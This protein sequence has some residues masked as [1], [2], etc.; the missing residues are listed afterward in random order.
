M[1][2]ASMSRA[3]VC[4]TITQCLNDIS[5]YKSSCC[6]VNLK[7]LL[8]SSS[9]SSPT[10]VASD[11]LHPGC[12]VDFHDGIWNEY[13]MYAVEYTLHI[14]TDQS[15]VMSTVWHWW[16]QHTNEAWWPVWHANKYVLARVLTFQLTD[17]HIS[18]LHI[19]IVLH[20]FCCNAN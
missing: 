5:D 15:A 1:S 11:H 19:A 2:Q 17:M 8:S 4:L 20:Q 16:Q 14:Q 13:H 10:S 12:W 18:M 6:S 9:S 3:R 7:L